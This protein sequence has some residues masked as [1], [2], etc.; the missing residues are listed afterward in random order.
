MLINL[1]ESRKSQYLTK[2]REENVNIYNRK[3]KYIMK[4]YILRWINKYL[5]R[6]IN[7]YIYVYK[8]GQT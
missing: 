8:I 7:T 1:V 4:I 5:F 3:N 6:I 2:Y